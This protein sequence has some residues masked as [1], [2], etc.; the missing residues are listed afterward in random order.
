MTRTIAAV[1]ASFL[2]LF[3]PMAAQ[4]GPRSIPRGNGVP[5]PMP[6]TKAEISVTLLADVAE[7]QIT[8]EFLNPGDLTEEAEF[9]LHPPPGAVVNGYALDVDGELREAVS[10]PAALA[11]TAYETVRNRR[12]DPGLVERVDDH[13]FRIRVYPVNPRK[14]RRCM[15]RYSQTLAPSD[16]GGQ[17]F[18]LPLDFG[19]PTES[20]TCRIRFPENQPPETN[21][22]T[23]ESR[24]GELTADLT[25][26]ELPSALVLTIP[27]QR[28]PAI[29]RDPGTNDFVLALPPAAATPAEDPPDTLTLLWDASLNGLG[30]DPANAFE[31][32]DKWFA[33]FTRTKVRLFFLRDQ[34]T[35]ARIFTIRNGRWDELKRELSGVDYDGMADLADFEPVGSSR[36]VVLVCHGPVLTNGAAKMP[37]NLTTIETGSPGGLAAHFSRKT[38]RLSDGRI[39]TLL[40]ALR[41]S[42]ERVI[43][44]GGATLARESA[45]PS[46]TSCSILPSAPPPAGRVW[47]FHGRMPDNLQRPVAVQLSGP[48]GERTLS[49]EP[50]TMD[51]GVVARLVAA[52]RLALME[53]EF[54]VCPSAIVTHCQANRLASEFTSLLVL[55]RIEDYVAHGI[56]PPE[57]PL[58]AQYDARIRQGYGQRRPDFADVWRTRRRLYQHDYPAID[59]E[60]SGRMKQVAIWQNAMNSQFKPG[61]RDEAAY[62]RIGGWLDEARAAIA[63]KPQL[64]TRAEFDD[65]SLKI[66]HLRES[67]KQLAV[68]PL[69]L[70]PADQ[71][72]S[73]SVRGLVNRPGLFT[74]K[75]GLTLRQS[76][77]LAGGVLPVG[78]LEAVALYRN[79]GMTIYNT[80]SRAYQDITLYPGDMI[81][82]MQPVPS[83]ADGCFADPF[84]EA[85]PSP[86]INPADKP[87]VR[88]RRDVWVTPRE[89]G[90]AFPSLAPAKATAPPP[91]QGSDGPELDPKDLEKAL[92][93]NEPPAAAYR[94]YTDN[95]R[96]LVTSYIEAARL[97]HAANQP[98][99]ARRVLSNVVA[100][101]PRDTASLATYGFWLAEFGATEDARRVLTRAIRL[102]PGA[103]GAR[104]ALASITPVDGAPLGREQALAA[105]VSPGGSAAANAIILTDCCAHCPVANLKPPHIGN[106]GLVVGD[107]HSLPAD[108][109]IVVSHSEEAEVRYEVMEPTNSVAYLN[110]RPTACGGMLTADPQLGEYLLKQAVPGCHIMMAKADRPVTLRVTVYTRWGTASQRSETHTIWLQPGKSRAIVN[111]DFDPDSPE[112]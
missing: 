63:R 22:L 11:R 107:F 61:Q 3:L 13:T 89:S 32:L 31:L 91:L 35:E 99:L 77:D 64:K 108:L 52:H 6:V 14:T 104:F 7:T 71:P 59:P 79:G 19:R 57:G 17:T 25:K 30:R 24:P 45:L 39:E 28:E 78:S 36:P 76:I 95:R 82:V 15:V 49:I 72:L 43:S 23:F 88:D 1:F 103:T 53:S 83:G 106:L 55:E 66:Q 100:L 60:L 69:R 2:G 81:V 109:R 85:E 18:S 68:T 86:P 84:A 40:E 90:E 20:F 54:P 33:G 9:I 62:T 37:D 8:M 10:V 75:P 16:S 93:A 47:R 101:R 44:V 110:G 80:R 70:P 41:S 105:C 34:C 5:V 50:Q 4:S 38:I 67:G 112:P 94:K 73:V 92:A 97:L 48:A 102:D 51:G 42:R 21:G 111:I 46:G 58:R 87:A 65:W 29:F 98:D 26:A 96:L 27:A 74:G 12:I 56:V